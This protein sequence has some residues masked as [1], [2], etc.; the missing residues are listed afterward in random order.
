[1]TSR[2]AAH[3][4]SYTLAGVRKRTDSFQWIICQRQISTLGKGGGGGEE[5]PSERVHKRSKKFYFCRRQ[6]GACCLREESRLAGGQREK[7][8]RVGRQK[9]SVSLSLFLPLS[10]EK[11]GRIRRRSERCV[12]TWRMRHK[13]IQK[14]RRE[15]SSFAPLSA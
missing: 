1:M 9:N 12:L 3:V 6:N 5:G 8:N 4:T 7:E 10:R 14:A 2:V 11:G 13:Q 15:P